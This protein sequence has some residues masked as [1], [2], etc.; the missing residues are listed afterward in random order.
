MSSEFAEFAEAAARSKSKQTPVG[1]SI[2]FRKI[3][4]LGGQYD[5]RLIAGLCLSQGCEVSLFSAYGAEL[6]SLRAGS[7]IVFGQCRR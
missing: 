6:E 5:A 1:A 4:V 2:E 7:G 3:A